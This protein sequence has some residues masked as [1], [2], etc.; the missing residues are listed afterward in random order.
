MKEIDK[1][2]TILSS[3]ELLYL[4]LF[5][6]GY[7]DNTII[8]GLDIDKKAGRVIKQQVKEILGRKYGTIYWNEIIKESFKDGLL[9]VHDHINPIIK[10]Q[11]RINAELIYSEFFLNKKPEDHFTKSINKK[12]IDYLK[13]CDLN[14]E[15]Q[16]NIFNAIDIFNPC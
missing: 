13:D 15:K 10:D 3:E 4:N 6:L 14:L 16:K 5:V 2:N 11:A 9:N 7:D 8:E 12:I 1:N